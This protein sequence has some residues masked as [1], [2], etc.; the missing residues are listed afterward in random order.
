MPIQKK[1]ND[2]NKKIADLK[3]QQEDLEADLAQQLLDVIKSQ[4][5][6]T[7][8]FSALVGGLLEILQTGKTDHQKMEAW[9]LAGE[10]FLKSQHR[11]SSKSETKSTANS[12]PKVA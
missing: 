4:S 10:K 3:L 2:L 9:Q 5:G 1:L 11:K 8:P 7:L 6:F 12:L